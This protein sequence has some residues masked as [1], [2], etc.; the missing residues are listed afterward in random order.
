MLRLRPRSCQIEVTHSKLQKK[1]LKIVEKSLIEHP[2]S[3]HSLQGGCEGS[4]CFSETCVNG[5]CA[6]NLY[7]YDKNAHDCVIEEGRRSV[8]F[9]TD[10]ELDVWNNVNKHKVLMLEGNLRPVKYLT[11]F[12]CQIDNQSLYAFQVTVLAEG[13]N[14][15]ASVALQTK[16]RVR[17]P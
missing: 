9:L 11:E 7:V 14:E 2:P 5:L 8:S 4:I 15:R 13:E 16:S 17:I 10:S 1:L 6:S 3:K 12:L